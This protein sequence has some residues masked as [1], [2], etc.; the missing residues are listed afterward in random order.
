MDFFFAK[1]KQ[2]EAKFGWKQRKSMVK[3]MVKDHGSIHVMSI[4]KT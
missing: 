3:I 1:K 2:T 4:Q